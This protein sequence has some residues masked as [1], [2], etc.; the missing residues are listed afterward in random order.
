M[1]QFDDARTLVEHSAAKLDTLRAL[2]AN[3]LVTRSITADFLV[4][5]KNFMEN[6]RSVLDYCA[7]GLFDK[8]GQSRN[9]RPNI[10]FP[11]VT[12][13][14][15]KLRFRNHVIERSIPGL[16][17]A[18]PDIVETLE[19]YQ[20]FGNTGNWLHLFMRITNENKHEQLTPQVEK[21]YTV[22]KLSAT[23]PAGETVKIDL[24]KIQ[25]GGGPDAPYDAVAGTWTGLVFTGTSVMVMLHLENAL[26]NVSR[27]V[28]EL[29]AA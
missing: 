21:K 12:P 6:L 7:H 28:E 10:Y 22:V 4:E 1:A 2:H 27:I 15:D 18:R 3:C 19:T 14:D 13:P 24:T 20:Y 11:Y 8:Y 29:S 26:Q 25:L 23:I 17:L 5:V 16:L 9:A